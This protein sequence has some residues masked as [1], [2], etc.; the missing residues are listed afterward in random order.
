MDPG[1]QAATGALVENQLPVSWLGR[2]TTPGVSG[3]PMDPPN[4]ATLVLNG[5]LSNLQLKNLL[6]QIAYNES[7]WDYNLIGS[8]N[9]LGRYQFDSQTLENYGLLAS[10]SVETYG[11]NAVTFRHCWQPAYNSYEDYSYNIKNLNG[12]L[13]NQAAQD[14][15]AYQLL[16]DTYSACINS[17]AIQDA[18]NTQTIAGMISVAWT[19]GTGTGPTPSESNGTGAW[20]WRYNNVGSGA[21][22]YNQGR[23]AVAVLSSTHVSVS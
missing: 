19:L 7:A 1:I 22:S 5:A 23:Y 4:W 6:A 2:I 17:G 20:A 18:D 3:M 11:N 16:I 12:F 8:N 15:L 14:H 13:T 9:K 10:G 21:V